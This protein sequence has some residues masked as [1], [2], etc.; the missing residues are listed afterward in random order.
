MLSQVAW[1]CQCTE[2]KIAHRKEIEPSEVSNTVLWSRICSCYKCKFT[3][4][5]HQVLFYVTYELICVFLLQQKLS[6]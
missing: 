4:D 3:L 6:S 2:H 1:G 5:L